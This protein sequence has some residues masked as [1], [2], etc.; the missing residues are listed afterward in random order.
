MRPALLSLAIPRED[1]D[2][3]CDAQYR[4]RKHNDCWDRLW[5]VEHHYRRDKIDE[6]QYEASNG[7]LQTSHP[8]RRSLARYPFPLPRLMD[9]QPNGLEP[10]HVRKSAG[11]PGQGEPDRENTEQDRH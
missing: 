1:P 4:T 6:R 3:K 11:E 10:R 8:V 9:G 2:P 5:L 7:D